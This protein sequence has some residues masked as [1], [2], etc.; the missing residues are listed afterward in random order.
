MGVPAPL[1]YGWLLLQST[2]EPSKDSGPLGYVMGL[3]TPLGYGWLILQSSCEPS[4]ILGTLGHVMVVP[5]PLP[6]LRLVTPTIFLKA[7]TGLGA[8]V[9]GHGR[10]NAPGLRLFTPTVPV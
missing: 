8:A 5:P 4:Q 1:G 3:P 10:A 7:F 9:K 6:G 2:N